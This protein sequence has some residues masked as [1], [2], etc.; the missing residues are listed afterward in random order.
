MRKQIVF[1][2]ILAIFIGNLLSQEKREIIGN[3]EKISKTSITVNGKS[4]LVPPDVVI[5]EKDGTILKNEEDKFDLQIL[6]A[7]EEVKLVL[8][9]E[10]MKEII[11]EVRRE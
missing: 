11:I 7:V 9:E 4:Y 1:L 8:V 3:L 10:K 5:K 6:R 2:F